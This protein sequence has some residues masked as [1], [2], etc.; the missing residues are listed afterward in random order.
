[1][2]SVRFS[3]DAQQDLEDAATWYENRRSGLGIEFAVEVRRAVAAIADFPKAGQKEG[4]RARSRTAD[5]FPYRIVYR[6]EPGVA[7]IVAV[8]H[9]KRRPAVLAQTAQIL[10]GL[11]TKST[12]Y[13][14]IE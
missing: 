6:L 12:V 3:A 2:I 1:M 4:H 10:K 5:R 7:T 13:R 11:V 8:V 9:T 14:P